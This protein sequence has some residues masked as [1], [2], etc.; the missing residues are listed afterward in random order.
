[1]QGTE[2]GAKL[3]RHYGINVTGE[4]FLRLAFEFA[5]ENSIERLVNAMVRAIYS[6]PI[7]RPLPKKEETESS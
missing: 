5:I 2:K 6:S 1:V 4:D 3:I 7:R